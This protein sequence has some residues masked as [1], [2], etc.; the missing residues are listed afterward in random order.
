MPSDS[1]QPRRAALWSLSQLRHFGWRTNCTGRA[2]EERSTKGN[3][4]GMFTK[5]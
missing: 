3:G 5:L 4:M 2:E 1:S